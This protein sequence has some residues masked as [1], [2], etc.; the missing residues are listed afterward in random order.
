MWTIFPTLFSTCE[1]HYLAGL[2]SFYTQPVI[3][4]PVHQYHP[5]LNALFGE[6]NGIVLECRFGALIFGKGN[7]T[8]ILAKQHCTLYTFWSL[9]LQSSHPA[10]VPKLLWICGSMAEIHN[11]HVPA[12]KSK[13]LN[14]NAHGFG[15]RIF[16]IQVSIYFRSYYIMNIQACSKTLLYN[17]FFLKFYHCLVYFTMVMNTVK[18]SY[19]WTR[20]LWNLRL[21]DYS[22]QSLLLK[23]LCNSTE[24]NKLFHKCLPRQIE[25][26]C[27][28]WRVPQWC[29]FNHH[30]VA[31]SDND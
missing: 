13:Q 4:S 28:I 27:I 26:R 18:L 19:F 3:Q 24:L 22:L 23:A 14:I 10:S 16:S 12:E 7:Q 15:I 17:F 31:V 2:G 25:C 20:L 29:Y 30:S 1:R 21:S 9:S 5:C 8:S 11:S 6:I